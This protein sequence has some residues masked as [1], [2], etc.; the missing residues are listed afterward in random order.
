MLSKLEPTLGS[1]FVMQQQPQMKIPGNGKQ[2]PSPQ[3]LILTPLSLNETNGTQ[4]QIQQQQPQLD[5][6][7]NSYGVLDQFENILG[8]TEDLDWTAF[9]QYLIDS[10]HEF[11]D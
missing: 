5:T 1:G 9:D 11:N 6:F 8:E 10:D 3:D 7:V 2:N 4:M